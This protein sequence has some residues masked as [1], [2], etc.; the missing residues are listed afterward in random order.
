MSSM[1]TTDTVI[2]DNK[3]TVYSANLFVEN[4]TG[5]AQSEV[6]LLEVRRL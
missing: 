5:K 1:L 2:H 4:K 3:A 6:R